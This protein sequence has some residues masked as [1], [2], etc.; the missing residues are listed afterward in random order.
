MREV[1]NKPYK[2]RWIAGLYIF[3]TIIIALFYLTIYLFG[4]LY[5]LPCSAQIIIGGVMLLVVLM[6]STLII[7]F[8]TTKY[9]IKDGLLASWSPFVAIKIKLKD[10][11]NIERII[12][13]FNLKVGA[14]F[15]CGFF[16][17]P[18][19]G[20]VRSIITNLRDVI[21]ITTKDGKYYMITPSNPERFMRMLKGKNQKS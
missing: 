15:Y 12:Y 8:Y 18:N 2:S 7:N 14:S 16:Y 1:V 11:K 4:E 19:L 10:I 21:L 13:P 5:L 6:L 9:K 20:W 17:V 3:L